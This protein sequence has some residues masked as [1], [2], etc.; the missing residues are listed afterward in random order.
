MMETKEVADVQISDPFATPVLSSF[1]DDDDDDND[2]THTLV[3]SNKIR[4]CL[5]DDH[6]IIYGAWDLGSSRESGSA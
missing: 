5:G 2:C 3:V 4:L 1:E 6:L